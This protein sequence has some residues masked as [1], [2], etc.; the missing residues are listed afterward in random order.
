MWQSAQSWVKSAGGLA[1]PLGING[2]CSAEGDA[3]LWLAGGIGIPL[4]VLGPEKTSNSLA[5]AEA[6][7]RAEW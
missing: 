4:G 6:Y 7:V 3:N 2:V 5:V 1:W